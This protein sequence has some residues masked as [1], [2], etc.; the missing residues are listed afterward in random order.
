ML[1]VHG[2]SVPLC[3]WSKQQ[4]VSPFV[5]SSLKVPLVLVL[6]VE[7]TLYIGSWICDWKRLVKTAN[8]LAN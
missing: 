3:W 2:E 6:T 5:C 7:V 8:L 4:K 1:V